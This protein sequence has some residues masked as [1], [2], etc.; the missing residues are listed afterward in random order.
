MVQVRSVRVGPPDVIKT[1]LSIARG[2]IRPKVRSKCGKGQ[3]GIGLGRPLRN[4]AACRLR[5]GAAC[6]LRRA[7][8]LQ[9]CASTRRTAFEL[10]H[11]LEKFPTPKNTPAHP[12]Q[13]AANRS[14]FIRASLPEKSATGWRVNKC[15]LFLPS[16]LGGRR[17]CLHSSRRTLGPFGSACLISPSR[18]QRELLTQSDS[19]ALHRICF[20]RAAP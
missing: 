10:R 11:T 13:S 5:N 3:L 18:P 9:A 17:F 6:R 16:M 7:K 2:Q 1:E 14:P 19:I 4:G 20:A 12:S 8:P 15:L